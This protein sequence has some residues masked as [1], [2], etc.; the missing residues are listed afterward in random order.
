M[1]LIHYTAY[2]IRRLLLS[3]GSSKQ[4]SGESCKHIRDVSTNDCLPS[5]LY[6]VQ[7]MEVCICITVCLS[8]DC[9]GSLSMGNKMN[10]D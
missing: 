3:F 4:L 6:W 5:K 1:I 9:M 7:E 2:S 10:I 8:I